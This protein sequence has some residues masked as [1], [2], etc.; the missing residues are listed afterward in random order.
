M[1]SPDLLPELLPVRADRGQPH[2][3]LIGLIAVATAIVGCGERGA[4]ANQRQHLTSP[5]G[6][7]VMTMLIGPTPSSWDIGVW[8]V[9]I[10]TPAGELLF[11]D[12]DSKFLASFSVYWVWDQDDRLWLYN[13]DDSDVYF[14]ARGSTDNQW[15]KV[16]WGQG[17]ANE[18]DCSPSGLY[19]PYV[20]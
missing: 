1:V 2:L 7:F 6:R 8:K 13:S 18:S 9:T 3:A 15:S 4:P 19:P 11:K 12:E 20:R 14:F 17:R 16:L 5:S 10:S